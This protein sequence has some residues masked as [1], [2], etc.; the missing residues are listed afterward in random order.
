VCLACT[1]P[2]TRQKKKKKEKGRER[3]PHCGGQIANYQAGSR[4]P[5]QREQEAGEKDMLLP[6]GI[7]GKNLQALAIGWMAGGREERFSGA[8]CGSGSQEGR[9]KLLQME[10]IRDKAKRPP[11]AHTCNPSNF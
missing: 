2:S 5:G 11:V 1:S 8:S 9:E 7:L 6:E 4:S 10:E 3:W